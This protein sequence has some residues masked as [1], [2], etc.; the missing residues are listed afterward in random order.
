MRN[1][2][3][4]ILPLAFACTESSVE[5][6]VRGDEELPNVENSDEL[7]RFVVGA[8]TFNALEMA[9]LD[10][11]GSYLT[12]PAMVYPDQM[13]DV[14]Y[15]DGSGSMGIRFEGGVVYYE[16]GTLANYRKIQSS[17][18]EFDQ[19]LVVWGEW[20]PM[21][22]KIQMDTDEVFVRAYV[23]ALGADDMFLDWDHDNPML[24]EDASVFF[25][26]L[27]RIDEDSL[28]WIATE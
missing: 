17:T 3:Y 25:I 10:A 22:E 18:G 11:D 12:T 20:E 8:W 28:D 16:D 23:T 27:S 6:E 7:G 4:L 15:A 19:E 13:V 1:P 2:V 9:L 14:P 5:D 21:S 26:D 24:E